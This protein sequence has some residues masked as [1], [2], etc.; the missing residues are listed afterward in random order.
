M[1][2]FV[3]LFPSRIFR[4]ILEGTQDLAYVGK[5]TLLAWCAGTLLSA[6]LVA[7]GNG[8]ISLAWGW[9]LTQM[10][11]T[12]LAWRRVSSRYPGLFRASQQGALDLVP[13]HLKSSIWVS[14]SQVAQVLLAGS[15]ALVVGTFLGP[16]AVV[17]YACT[18]K[19]SSVLA[20]QPQAIMQ[21]AL[22]GLSEIRHALDPKRVRDI[23][24]ALTLAMLVLSGGIAC[25]VLAGNRAFVTWW[26]SAQQYAGGTLTLLFVLTMLFRHWNTTTVYTMFAFGHERRI[27]LTTVLDGIVTIATSLV[28]VPRLGAQ[29]VLFGSLTGVL[30]ISLPSNLRTTLRDTQETATGMAFFLVPWAWRCAIVAIVAVAASRFVAEKPP[31]VT[32]GVVAAIGA[33]YLLLVLP[34]VL[35]GPCAPYVRPYLRWLPANMLSGSWTSAS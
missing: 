1:A 9:L 35:R 34:L 19:L 2:S 14:V 6:L 5:T 11:S 16:A 31:L 25:V 15:D 27:S 28:L 21:A 29:G 24:Q 10:L 13:R 4:A 33:L 32:L 22:P 30:L 7:S 8:L 3:L 20:N 17:P 23:T 12:F 18:G 26:V